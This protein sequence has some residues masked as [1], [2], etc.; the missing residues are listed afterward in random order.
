M[1]PIR[2]FAVLAGTFVASLT[3][4][5]TGVTPVQAA[6]LSNCAHAATTPCFETVWANG[7]QFKMTFVNLNFPQTTSAP[8]GKFYVVASQIIGMPQGTVPFLHDHVVPNTPSQNHGDYQVHLH[9]FFVLCSAYGISTGTCV[10]TITA[11]PGLGTVP[12]AKTVNGQMLTSVEAI[13]SSA[14]S[15]SLMLLDTGAVLL[16]TITS[17]Q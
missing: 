15:P 14:N 10:P 9:G 4:V 17:G 12:F 7:A 6:G 11:I 2:K 5:T 1:N 3:L 8:T 13:E 16:A